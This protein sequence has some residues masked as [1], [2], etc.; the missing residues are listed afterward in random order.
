MG[1]GRVTVGV[2]H[3][4]L[5]GKADLEAELLQKQNWLKIIKAI[6]QN[7]GRVAKENWGAVRQFL[8]DHAPET[9]PIHAGNIQKVD[10]FLDVVERYGLEVFFP[11]DE[12]VIM[13]GWTGTVVGGE[14]DKFIDSIQ[15]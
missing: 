9:S 7:D 14:W 5:S 8:I 6:Y 13:S 3:T 4:T 15:A 1:L 10:K 2:L 12:D 11:T